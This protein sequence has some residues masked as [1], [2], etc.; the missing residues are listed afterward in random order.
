MF[1]PPY[2]II[3]GGTPPPALPT[4]MYFLCS[5][6]LMYEDTGT[7]VARTL[8]ACLPLLFRPCS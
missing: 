5:L 8:L 3:G 7:S 4:P 1:P 2:K 6:A